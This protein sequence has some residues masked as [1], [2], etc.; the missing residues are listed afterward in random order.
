MT[1]IMP[2]CRYIHNHKEAQHS[3]MQFSLENTK[4]ISSLSIVFF[5]SFFFKLKLK[6]LDTNYHAAAGGRQ[7]GRKNSHFDN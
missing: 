2:F 7:A 4:K 5:V 6:Q 1:S 3:C